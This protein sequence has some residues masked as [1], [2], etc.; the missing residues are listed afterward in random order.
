MSAATV[1]ALAKKRSLDAGVDRQERRGRSRE[2]ADMC[3]MVT[4]GPLRSKALAA[5]VHRPTTVTL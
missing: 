5:P 2:R 4:V 1:G 3:P